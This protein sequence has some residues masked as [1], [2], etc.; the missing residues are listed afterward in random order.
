MLTILKKIGKIVWLILGG[1][2]T[3]WV[4]YFIYKL[5]VI[6]SPGLKLLSIFFLMLGLALMGIYILITITGKIIG[7]SIKKI[8]QK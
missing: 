8:K 1:F 4:G 3:L 5:Q 6:S 7:F 2:I